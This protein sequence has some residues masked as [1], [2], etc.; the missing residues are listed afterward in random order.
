MDSL[1][2]LLDG[3]TRVQALRAGVRAVEDRLATIELERIVERL[4]TSLGI[5][6]VEGQ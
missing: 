3:T 4:E 5:T 2:D 1:L 6:C